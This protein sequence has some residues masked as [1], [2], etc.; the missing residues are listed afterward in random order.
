MANRL[1]TIQNYIPYEFYAGDTVIWQIE[2]LHTDYSNSTHTLTYKFR[3]ENNGSTTFSVDATADGNNYKITLGASTTAS[4]TEGKY[5]F[6]SYVTRTSDNARVTVDRG[7]VEVKPNL[8]SST[9]ETRSHAKKMLDLIESLLEGKAT[10]DVSSYSI[11]GRSLNKMSVSELL[12][13]RNYYKTEY[14]REISKQRNENEDGSGNTIKISFGDN[15]S[16][17]YYDHLKNR[18]YYG[19]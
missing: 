13:W 10:K 4:I 5:N 16:L 7:M 14:N 6:I 17:G 11:A 19:N 3:L 12:E 2:N 8:A 9:S 1:T 18:K 15:K